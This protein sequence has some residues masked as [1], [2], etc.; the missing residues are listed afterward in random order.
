MSIPE[1]KTSILKY[2]L[3]S[4]GLGFFL[5]FIILYVY[6]VYTEVSV[7]SNKLD[8]SL[9]LKELVNLIDAI[10]SIVMAFVLG[11]FL[12]FF[13]T[14]FYG[15]VS[16]EFLTMFLF[17][18]ILFIAG[19]KFRGRKWA[20]ASGALGVALYIYAGVLGLPPA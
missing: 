17:S 18:I 8:T 20:L 14:F 9:A 19:L 15:S 13:G 7:M 3:T 6:L 2:A 1:S 12:G 5:F 16:I 4:I 10:P 11:P